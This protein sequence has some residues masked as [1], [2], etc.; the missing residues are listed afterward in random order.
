MMLP[1]I[2][3]TGT[4]GNTVA[5]VVACAGAVGTVASGVAA[6]PA[7]AGASYMAFS[8]AGYCLRRGVLHKW[9]HNDQHAGAYLGAAEVLRRHLK[10][11]DDWHL[12][13]GTPLHGR[14]MHLGH[15]AGWLFIF[16]PVYPLLE[17]LLYPFDLAAFW[18]YYPKARGSGLVIDGCALRRNGKRGNAAQ[19]FRLDWHRFDVN[20][21]RA[22]PP[23]G[24]RHPPSVTCN[25]PH[26]DLPQRGVRHW[27]WR[28]HT[29]RLIRILP[30]AKPERASNIQD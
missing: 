25:L 4:S 5:A 14:L 23:P 13:S 16:Q 28:Q 19:V 3:L 21:G 9:P 17:A 27:P 18:F 1:R 10:Y 26:I 24:G 20:V 2:A 7:I 6:K 30:K 15:V 22:Y 12:P 29:R 8:V 11:E